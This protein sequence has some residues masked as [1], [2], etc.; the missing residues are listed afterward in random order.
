MITDFNNIKNEKDRE[1]YVDLR[2]IL[3]EFF[4]TQIKLHNNKDYNFN[5]CEV[6]D[7]YKELKNMFPKQL[8]Q[9]CLSSRLSEIEIIQG[10]IEHNES[11]MI[12]YMSSLIIL[13]A[14]YN[15][16]KQ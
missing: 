11:N 12:M 16:R 13:K 9:E 15:K 3:D 2:N 5:E 6:F 1:L 10:W 7:V 8:K 14:E 4:V